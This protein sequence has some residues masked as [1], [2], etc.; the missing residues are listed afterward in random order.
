MI[1]QSWGRVTRPEHE[2]RQLLARP[3]Q[4]AIPAGRKALAYGQG[5]SYGDCCLNGGG[6]LYLTER[7]NQCLELNPNE[8]WVRCDAGMTLDDLLRLIVPAGFFLPVTPG[9]KYISV[10]GAIAND[11]HGKNHHGAGT[12]G[13]HVRKLELVRSD[14]VFTCS[15]DENRELFYATI[16][17][18][19]LTG[20]ITWA[21][22]NLQRIDTA[23]IDVEEIK[24]HGVDEFLQLSQESDAAWEHTVAWTDWASESRLFG[25]GVFIRG[26][27]WAQGQPAPEKKEGVD[28]LR[29]LK[30]HRSGLV[31]LPLSA[32]EF[33]L[34]SWSM[35][36]FNSVYFHKR[37]GRQ[38]R[39]LTH[40]DAFFYPLDMITN[41][42]RMYGRRGFFQYQCVLPRQ[43]EASAL[44]AVA[45]KLRTSRERATLVILKKFG[46]RHS[47][48]LLSFPCA[49]VTAAIDFANNGEPTRALFRELDAIVRECGGRH[50]TAKDACMSPAD[51]A[52][53]YPRLAEFQRHVDPAFSSDLWRRVTA[54]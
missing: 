14:G 37:R 2:V 33:V 48:G 5:R 16:G 43:D 42:S 30:L 1:V 8:G 9:T 18:I 28:P 52:R 34:N 4:L 54:L 27:H 44:R 49:G 38:N 26:R 40:Y 21:E 47:G 31:T 53:G 23:Y 3:A 36:A 11:V 32:P 7:M 50:Y 19:G 13:C 6:L 39:F 45:E 25:R 12:I 20:L 24:F 29:R 51:F 22:I 17:G 10:G 46:E 41:W 15:P 35:R